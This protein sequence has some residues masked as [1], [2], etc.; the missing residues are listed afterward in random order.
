MMRKVMLAALALPTFLLHAQAN[1]PATTMAVTAENVH[2]V[3]T[4]VVAPRLIRS[5]DFVADAQAR[6]WISN[7]SKF[8]V[9]MIVDPAGKPTDLK[10]VRSSFVGLN[11]AVLASVSQ[12]RCAPGTIDNQPVAV[13]VSLEVEITNALY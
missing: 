12:Y 5:S 4:G 9:S 3:S 7:G 6:E 8:V 2:R 13:P 1:P 11:Q 10:I